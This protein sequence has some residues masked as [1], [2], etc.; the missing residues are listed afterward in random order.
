MGKLDEFF[1]SLKGEKKRSELEVLEEIEASIRMGELESAIELAESLENESNRFLALRMV[2]RA[3]AERVKELASSESDE[4]HLQ[5]MRDLAKSLIPL[6]NSILNR[7]YRMLLLAD[8]AVLFY[9]LNDELNGDVALRTAI[10]MAEN[11]PDVIKDIL[12][13]LIHSGLLRKAGYAMKM[14]RDREKLDVV[15]VHLAELFYRS[16]DIERAKLIIEHISNPFHRAMA[17]YYIATIEGEKDPQRALKILDAAFN[18]AEKV[19]DPEARFE[20]ILKLYDLK[21]KLTGEMPSLGEILSK[22]EVP[23]P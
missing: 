23:P 21:G 5:E 12:F 15:L 8:L 13:E 10:N 2:L 3:I 19:K 22:K 4:E 11:S 14:V 1:R 6:I 17:L 18:V 9:R 7:R 16:G 20:L